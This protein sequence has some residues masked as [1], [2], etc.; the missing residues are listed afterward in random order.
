MGKPGDTPEPQGP[1]PEEGSGPGALRGYAAVCHGHGT[2]AAFTDE[3]DFSPQYAEAAEV[4]AGMKVMQGYDDGSFLPQRNITRAQ[5][6]TLIY[7]AATG[8]VTDS[9]TDIYSDYD[10][11]DDV[12]ST[13]WFA[14]YVNYCANGELIKGFTPDT[15]G[16]NKNVTGYQVLAM[17]LRA[18]VMTRTTSSPAPA[19]RFALPPPPRNLAC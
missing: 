6:A 7:R 17:I 1:S 4:L 14:G 15:F 5:V 11:F 9:Q 18:W 3:D 2:G 13:D 8:D 16:P 12:Q 10:K 19:G